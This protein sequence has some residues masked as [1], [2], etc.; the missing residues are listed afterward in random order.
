MPHEMAEGEGVYENTNGGDYWLL[1]M[2]GFGCAHFKKLNST[3]QR[4]RGV[5][6]CW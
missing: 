5:L 3:G 2:T 1:A 4:N 6:N